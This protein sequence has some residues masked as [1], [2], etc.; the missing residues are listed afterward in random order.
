MNRRVVAL[1]VAGALAIAAGFAMVLYLGRADQRAVA[2][3][4]ATKVW[5]ATGAIPRGTTLKAAEQ[6]GM[7]RQDTVPVRSAP[8]QAARQLGAADLVA[9]SDIAAGEI[10][11]SGRFAAADSV[12]PQLLQIPDGHLALSATLSDP[13]R[14]GSFVKPGDYVAVVYY[15]DAAKSARVLLPRV[16]VL[17]VGTTSESGPARAT[18]GDQVPSAVMT[19]AVAN[20]DVT[21]FVAA[22]GAGRGAGDHLYFALLPAG[23]SAQTGVPATVAG[24]GQ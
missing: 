11:M 21:R 6:K 19:L 5:V 3:Q 15:D 1:V 2:G 22:A 10:I 4:E 14:V 17:G 7:L 18:S 12:G 23:A 16:Q 13:E 8:S 20:Q 9:S 24:G